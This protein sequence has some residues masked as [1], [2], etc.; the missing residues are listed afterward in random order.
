MSPLSPKGCPPL[1]PKGCHPCHLTG[2]TLVTRRMS[3]LSPKG[4]TLQGTSFFLCWRETPHL[5]K[6]GVRL[7]PAFSPEVEVG[8][9]SYVS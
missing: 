8:A 6:A 5:M 7:C 3:P 9:M 4:V 2:V 1:S